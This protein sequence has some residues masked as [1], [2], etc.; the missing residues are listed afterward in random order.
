MIYVLGQFNL[1]MRIV[2]KVF[3]RPLAAII[4]EKVL[5]PYGFSET[6]WR[7]ENN[8]NLVW[9][10]ET[11]PAMVSFGGYRIDIAICQN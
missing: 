8:E 1:L 4:E 11:L 9:V 5:A 2:Q 7:K 6:G 10:N 3:G